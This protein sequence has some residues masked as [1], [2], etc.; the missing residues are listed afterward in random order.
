LGPLRGPLL[1][2]SWPAAPHRPR[3]GAVGLRHLQVPSSIGTRRRGGSARLL[4]PAARRRRWPR[5][6]AHP[7][8]P[9]VPGRDM[10]ASWS[11]GPG[12]LRHL[13]PR[14]G[15]DR[16]P[17]PV[18]ALPAVADRPR[19]RSLHSTAGARLSR[20]RAPSAAGAARAA[21]TGCATSATAEM[22][23]KAVAP[24]A[25]PGSP[26][27]AT[28][29]RHRRASAPLTHHPFWIPTASHEL[30]RP[31]VPRR[32]RPEAAGPPGHEQ[33]PR[34][35]RLRAGRTGSEDDGLA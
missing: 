31:A 20:V 25:T 32:G 27:R 33:A 3:P 22:S 15:G 30:S 21:A 18:L 10:A 9:R 5:P 6:P 8:P 13:P 11:R 1:W 16:H 28:L 12:S 35:H 26:K 23:R 2:S 17:Q 19:L 34:P 24:T 29:R 7:A 4:E 14:R